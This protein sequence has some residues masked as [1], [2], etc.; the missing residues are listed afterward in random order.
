ML[1]RAGMFGDV[2]DERPLGKKIK[3]YKMLDDI[4]YSKT[5][6]YETFL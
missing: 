5:S 1:L 6:K 2:I 4:N 3:R